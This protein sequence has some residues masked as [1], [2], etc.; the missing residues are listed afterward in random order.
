MEENQLTTPVVLIIFNRPETTKRVFEIIRAARPSQLFIVADGPREDHPKDAEKCTAARAIV[1]GVD[2][3]CVVFTN[4][5]DNNLGCKRRVSSGLDWVFNQV[6]QAIIL[7]DDCLPH[8]SFFYFCQEL[9]D[10]YQNDNRVM[11]ISGDNFQPIQDQSVFSY[12]FSRYTH[13]WGWATWRRA[14]KKFDVNM[15]SWPSFR[16][17]GWL[18]NILENRQDLNYWEE[19]FNKTF[20]GEI[21]SWAY[22]L[23]FA[24]WSQSL[25]AIS[26]TFNLVSNIGFGIDATHT[27]G[28]NEQANMEI[29]PVDFPLKHPPFVIRDV[30]ADRYTQKH[31]FSNSSLKHLLHRIYKKVKGFLKNQDQ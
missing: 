11:L 19:T 18:E 21:N 31:L 15:N 29:F 16:N 5:A 12:Y 17:G 28:V 13:I 22:A 26:P 20:N 9:L 4:Y 2:W 1:E 14:W 10:R 25:L 7:E 27:T 24:C 6:E 30:N 8:P 3:K 23:L